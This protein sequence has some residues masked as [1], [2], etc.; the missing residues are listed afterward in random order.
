VRDL[1]GRKWRKQH[2][3]SGQECHPVVAEN[4]HPCRD[5]PVSPNNPKRLFIVGGESLNGCA[6]W[7]STPEPGQGKRIPVP[8]P[9]PELRDLPC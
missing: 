4:T 7:A 3:C 6:F 9:R 2:S 5:Q 1:P 8:S